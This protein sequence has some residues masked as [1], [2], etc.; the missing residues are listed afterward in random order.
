LKSF[1]PD[2]VQPELFSNNRKVGKKSFL[3]QIVEERVRHISQFR[4]GR[5]EVFPLLIEGH[6]N[7]IFSNGSIKFIPNLRLN[8]EQIAKKSTLFKKKTR[9]TQNYSIF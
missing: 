2:Y 7:S 3:K 4:N 1:D 5:E 8:K 9:N 6:P